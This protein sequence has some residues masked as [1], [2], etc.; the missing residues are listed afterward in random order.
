MKLFNKNCIPNK[1][2]MKHECVGLYKQNLCTEN[3]ISL[4]RTLEMAKNC[5][6]IKSD[7]QNIFIENIISFE[8][9]YTNARTRAYVCLWLYVRIYWL[10]SHEADSTLEVT[11]ILRIKF[12]FY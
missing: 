9:K 1:K 2:Y 5:G 7:Y 10:L 6:Q 11:P 12:S 8:T 3:A 4:L